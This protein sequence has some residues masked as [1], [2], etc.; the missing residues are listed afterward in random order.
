MKSYSTHTVPYRTWTRLEKLDSSVCS[1]H[2]QILLCISK[3]QQIMPRCSKC[4]PRDLFWFAIFGE[5]TRRKAPMTLSLVHVMSSRLIK[6][7][8]RP[9]TP[10]PP[11]STS[12]EQRHEQCQSPLTWPSF[13]TTIHSPAPDF[14]DTLVRKKCPRRKRQCPPVQ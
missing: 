9:R 4:M 7:T 12:K 1:E 10:L 8:D 13:A 6:Y 14:A 5:I 11:L 2:A 3:S